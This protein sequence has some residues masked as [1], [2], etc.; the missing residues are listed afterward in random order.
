MAPSPSTGPTGDAITSP[1]HADQKF[2]K[3]RQL[4][5]QLPPLLQSWLL[6]R[7]SVASKEQLTLYNVDKEL[8]FEGVNQSGFFVLG[9]DSVPGKGYKG[10]KDID[11]GEEVQDDDA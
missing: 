1:G 4:R 9:Q 6:L 5:V 3:L 10:A 7:R 11:F 2:Q 8:T